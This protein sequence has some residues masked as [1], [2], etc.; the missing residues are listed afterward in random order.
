MLYNI[1]IDYEKMYL[2]LRCIRSNKILLLQVLVRG[3]GGCKCKQ[4]IKHKIKLLGANF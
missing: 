4:L 2:Y 1:I 3:K